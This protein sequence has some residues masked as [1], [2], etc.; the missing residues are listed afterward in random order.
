VPYNR[1]HFFVRRIENGLNRVVLQWGYGLRRVVRRASFLVGNVIGGCGIVW[2]CSSEAALESTPVHEEVAD[3]RLVE[4]FSWWTAPGEAEALNSL[5]SVHQR[6]HLEARMF[7][8]AAASGTSARDVLSRRIAHGDPPDLFQLNAHDV[9]RFLERNPGKL[10]PLDEMFDRLKLREVFYPE[11]INDV[12]L[13]NN[14]LSMPVNMHRENALFYNV[15]LFADNGL[16]PPTTLAEL[17]STCEKFR[18]NGITPIATSHQGW[19][20]RIMFSSLA[21]GVMGAESYHETFTG[22]K[23]VDPS[24]LGKAVA[25]LAEIL[26]KYSNVDAGEDGFGWTNAVQTVFTGEA[27]MLFHGDWAKG[28]FIQLGFIPGQDFGVVGAPGAADLF[29]YGVDVFA[30]PTGGINEKGAL[31]FLATVASAQGQVA[32]NTLK[33]SSPVRTDL[34]VGQLDPLARRTVNDLRTAKIR[35]LVHTRE[36]WD[37]AFNEFAKDRRQD[38]LLRVLVDYPPLQ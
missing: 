34:N 20:L 31:D 2:G 37:D 29:L 18:A 3:A 28:Y 25:L 30:M 12:K 23:T 26:D 32:F 38:K 7:N 27:A 11:V 14:I 9:A 10:Q 24:E 4:L 19:I 5:I 17:R 22:R 15:K 21:M 16:E 35:M 13:G 6:A 33:G 36:Q 1:G 8:A